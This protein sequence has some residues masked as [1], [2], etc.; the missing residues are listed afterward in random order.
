M[1]RCS[2]QISR[3][4]RSN[5]CNARENIEILRGRLDQA[6]TNN[7]VTKQEKLQLKEDLDHAYKEEEVFWQQKSR[8][9]WLRSDDRNTA[10]FHAVTKGKRCQNNIS[11]IQDAN[12]VVQQG[13]A[14]IGNVAQDYF[15][16]LFTSSTTDIGMYDRVFMGFQS[17]VSD[18][19]NANITRGVTYEEIRE[20][21]FDIGSHRTPGPDGFTAVF[22]HQ[23]WN[24]LKS[25]IVEEV[26][27]VFATGELDK[28]LNH[29]N[30]CLIPKIYPP[31]GMSDFRPISLCNVAYKVIS[32]ILVNRLKGHLDSLITENQQAFIPR[33]V[34]TDNIIVAHEV[35][36][37]LKVRKRQATSYMALKIDI[38][39][40]YDRLELS[41]LQETMKRMGFCST[42]IKRIMACVSTVSFSVLINGSQEGFIEP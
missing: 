27:P 6:I 16:N 2:Q 18:E 9:T 22:Y 30:I 37:S 36:H 1:V 32:K 12:G 23:Y 19:V 21:M 20:A 11:S 33:R 13:Q 8:V 34:I 5:R 15:D 4:K 41:F 35:F 10:Y 25:E 14:N 7:N 17:K 28:K 29:T 40:A 24:D 31:S 3:W 39:K 42:W 38:T 26:Q